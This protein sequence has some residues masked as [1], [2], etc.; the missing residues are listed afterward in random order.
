MPEGPEVKLTVDFLNKMLYNQIIT[1]WPMISGQYINKSPKGYKEFYEDLP[2]M[3]E[4]VLCKGKQ[5]CFVLFNENRIW[6]VTHSLRM[7]GRWQTYSDPCCRWYMELDN[8]LKLWFRDP[9]CFATLSF[10][11]V[12]DEHKNSFNSLGPDI[13]SDEFS[14]SAWQNIVSRHGNKNITSVLMNQNII[15]GCGNYIKAEV[16]YYAKISPLR[17][18]GSLSESESSRVFEGLR[19]ISR[20]SYAYKGVS[21]R[22]YSDPNGVNGVFQDYLK[23]YGNKNA[24]KTK[25]P[26]GRVTHWDPS[27][28][29]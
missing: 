27:I 12:E 23:I 22:D 1:D 29:K 24:T 18:L 16:L 28:Q 8:N 21:I 17:T 6:Y 20:L 4:N 15:S 14:F 13:L 7:T 2:M 19:V 26:D 25:T 11:T 9:R 3:V 10:T 5:I